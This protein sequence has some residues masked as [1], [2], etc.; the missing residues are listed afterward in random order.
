MR[1]YR[2]LFLLFS[3]FVVSFVYPYS[4]KFSTAGF[5]PLE[6]TGRQTYS[7]NVAW[8]F[9]KG[10]EVK[11]ED[12]EYDDTKWQVVSVPHGI[13]YLPTEAKLSRCGL[14]SQAF[15]S[16][17]RMDWKESVPSFRSDHG[18]V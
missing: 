7:M 9:F 16:G 18:K 13:E 14:V 12:K 3:L 17:R 6:H 8:R 2:L 1:K 11:A 5:Y 15:Q 10:D 4:P